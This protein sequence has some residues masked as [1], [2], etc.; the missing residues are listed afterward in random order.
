[1]R[2]P[3]FMSA[4]VV[5][6]TPL[7]PITEAGA[8]L[9][10]HDITAAPVVDD[11]QRLVGIVSESD[12]LRG[13]VGPD[14]RTHAL[15]TSIDES[16][17]PHTVG[18]VMTHKVVALPYT[19]DEADFAGAMLDHRVKSVP[20]VSGGRVVGIVSVSDLLRTRVRSDDDIATDVRARLREYAEGREPWTTTVADGVVTIAGPMAAPQRRVAV[21][22]AQT[23]PGAVRVRTDAGAEHAPPDRSG[24]PLTA[25][26]DHRE[27]RVLGLEECLDRLAG[28]PVGRLAF[29][30]DGEPT[31][32]PVNHGVDG[33]DVV[34]R[35]TWGAKL[36]VAQH[37][38]QVAFEVDGWD[39]D[40]ECG[41]SVLV[42]GTI[43]IV[44][45][46][47]DTDRYDS[48]GVPSWTG[49][50][51]QAFWLRLRPAEV[52]G[53]EFGPRAPR[54]DL[55]DPRVAPPHQ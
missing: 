21:L 27:L 51:D 43:G 10:G 54:E 46:T 31:V 53:R 8:L 11:D 33:L 7:T 28:V 1:M 23:V 32:L 45:E 2:A 37:Q 30:H 44:Y 38:G 16:E 6:V 48:L 41:W 39:S 26:A 29:M 9:L 19:A 20:V 5:T 52:T 42:K 35:T 4:P 14:P 36:Q 55:A 24:R 25:P 17:P 34:F 13:R 40:T 12:L 49:L 50:D 47:E 15:P 3:E 22:L 18:E